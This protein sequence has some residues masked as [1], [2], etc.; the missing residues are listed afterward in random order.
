MDA[1]LCP[2]SSKHKYRY[3]LRTAC[4]KPGES[5]TACV[6][7]LQSLSQHCAY[8]DELTAKM[9]RVAFAFGIKFSASCF[10][11][12]SSLCRQQLTLLL[13]LNCCLKKHQPFMITNLNNWCLKLLQIHL[14]S[15]TGVLLLF[16]FV[17]LH[18]YHYLPI[19]P[20]CLYFNN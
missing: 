1:H 16:S 11:R 6:T 9:L 8:K 13:W 7:F 14:D 12:T 5:I 18:L 15:K 3:E 2:K 19:L 17:E 4:C 20:I 10:E